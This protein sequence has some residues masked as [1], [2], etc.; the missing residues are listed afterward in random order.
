ME[1]IKV[2][3]STILFTALLIT[4]LILAYHSAYI[5]L[6]SLVGIGMGVLISP[7]LDKL[8]SRL[9]F[10]RALSG[11]VV[12]LGL[13]VFFLGVGLAIYLL[14]A[15]QVH[16]LVEKF[17]LIIEE[18]DQLTRTLFRRFPW[19]ED[20]ITRFELGPAARTGL[21]QLYSGI[22]FG[23]TSFTGAIFAVVI[24]VYTALYSHEYFDTLIEAI[25][26]Q[27]KEKTKT[28]LERSARV[29]R[30][31]FGALLL[32]MLIIGAITALGLW[33]SGADYWGVFGLLTAVLGVIPYVGIFF[34]IL[35]ASL[36]TL[37]SDP[38][39]L[40]WVLLVFAITQQLEGNLIIPIIMKD[41]VS[42]PVVPLLLFMLFMGK[43]FGVLGVFLAPPLFA[44]L[45]T[46]YVNVYLPFINRPRFTSDR[47][48]S[49]S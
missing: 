11:A 49:S 42:I 19:V 6:L 15:E 28:V 33:I 9:H 46:V 8:Q 25:A 22:K 43:F 1:K 32:D 27:Y 2:T 48:R 12:F 34:V 44:V 7:I 35:T 37:A 18:L 16:T 40:P 23:F 45:Q 29:L 21:A 39:K 10:P 24:G 31:W 14:V 30:D 17:P 20:Q 38:G 36:I 13:I 5:I 3:H 41:K 47:S 4:T 26:P